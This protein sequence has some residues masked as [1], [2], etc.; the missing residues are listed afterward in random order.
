MGG[1]GFGKG[2]AFAQD[3]LCSFAD[4][5]VKV[6]GE[7]ALFFGPGENNRHLNSDIAFRALGVYEQARSMLQ[8]MPQE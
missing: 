7:R 8:S 3:H 1:L 6:R 4:Q 2:V 5:V